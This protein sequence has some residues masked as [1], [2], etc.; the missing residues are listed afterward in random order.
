LIRN[1]KLD[2]KT[3]I[4][5]RSQMPLTCAKRS[6]SSRLTR[7]WKRKKLL[8]KRAEVEERHSRLLTQKRDQK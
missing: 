4:R 7:Q 1:E 2:E 5:L 8:E 3:A 6:R